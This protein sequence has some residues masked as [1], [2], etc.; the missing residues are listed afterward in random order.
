M[1]TH[2]IKPTD[3]KKKW[4]VVDAADQPL[5]RMASQIAY[6]LRGKHKPSFVP[7][8]DCGD[9]V[10]VINAGKVKLTGQKWENKFY[11]HHSNHIGGIKATSAKELRSTYPDRIV[12]LA[13]KGML[14]GNKL[15]RKIIKNLKV[16]EG[17]VH[18]HE[19]QKPIPVI[20]RTN[21]TGR[22]EK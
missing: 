10:I 17:D 19:S 16:Y 3:I 2:K 6:I 4:Y 20:E 15:G 18:P 7:H 12:S 8:L 22:G 13:V 9:N 14:P 21:L 1:K 11:Y 5:G